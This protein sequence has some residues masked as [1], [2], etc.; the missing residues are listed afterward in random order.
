MKMR[1]CVSSPREFIITYTRVSHLPVMA[2]ALL[3]LRFGASL[4]VVVVWA[5]QYQH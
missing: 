2:G 5:I 1:V 4:G 3:E